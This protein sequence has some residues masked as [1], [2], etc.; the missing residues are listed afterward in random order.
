LVAPVPARTSDGQI[1]DL[2]K[3]PELNRRDGL[4]KEKQCRSTGMIRNPGCVIERLGREEYNRL[5]AEHLARETGSTRG[6]DGNL[7]S[8]PAPGRASSAFPWC[9]A[10]GHYRKVK[11]P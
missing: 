11:T 4:D 3:D 9:L 7:R 10:I 1:N 6:S 8:K 2:E 5:Q